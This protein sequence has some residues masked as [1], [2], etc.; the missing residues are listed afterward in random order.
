MMRVG[1]FCTG[2]DGIGISLGVNQGKAESVWHSEIEPAAIAILEYHFPGVPNL[3]DLK[4][5]DWAKVEPVDIITAGFPCQP[6]SLAGQRKGADD[7]RHL[8]P[9]IAE[10]IGEIRPRYVLLENVRGLLTMGVD[11]VLGALVGMGYDTRHGLVR[12]SD[13]GA[14]HQRARLF[15]LAHLPNADGERGDGRR[16]ERP[17]WRAEPAHHGDA[18]AALDLLPTPTAS[19]HKGGTHPERRGPRPD[20]RARGKSD[21]RLADVM[22]LLPT[23]TGSQYGNNQSGTPGAAVRPSLTS[24]A[25]ATEQDWVQ[26]EPAIRRWEAVIGRPAP[27]PTEPGVRT[28]RR[29]A[30]PFAE[31]MMGLPE[32]W[33]TSPAIGLKRTQQLKAIG[34]GVVPQQ[35]YLAQR[36]LAE[37]E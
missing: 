17:G 5:I 9:F 24:M 28:D 14:P 29:L 10:A 1:S 15:I 31:W 18:A 2:Y 12:A 23:P 4:K 27:S 20:G 25:A 7:P 19:D 34:N 16:S 26:Y 21:C 22:T 35:S 32:G 36:L 3:G 33:V 30:A 37:M 6:F 13:A 11:V 8:W